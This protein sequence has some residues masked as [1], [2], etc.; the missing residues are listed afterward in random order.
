MQSRLSQDGQM[1]AV[2]VGTGSTQDSQKQLTQIPHRW[3]ASAN[4]TNE[5]VTR[6]FLMLQDY[7]FRVVHRPG[8]E[9][10]NADALSR[11]DACLW[12]IRG[13]PGFRLG[14]GSCDNP[15]PPS[16]PRTAPKPSRAPQVT[17]SAPQ[18][19]PQGSKPQKVRS[20]DSAPRP[21]PRLRRAPPS[22]PSGPRPP[23]Q[24][25]RA[26]QVCPIPQST[27]GR[28]SGSPDTNPGLMR[29]PGIKG[30]RRQPHREKRVARVR[31][32]AKALPV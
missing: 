6:W 21:A 1:V 2:P 18:T 9:N 13:D 16:A 32:D 12:A 28:G 10:A 11:R 5:R 23:P 3:M 31:R 15:C 24:L 29:S 25:G 17:P 19:A 26:P 27:R 14:W 22:R 30:Q 7:N 20:S 4:I 8:R